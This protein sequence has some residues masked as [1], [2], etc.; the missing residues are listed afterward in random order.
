MI[1]NIFLFQKLALQWKACKL[2]IKYYTEII[3]ALNENS[4]ILSQIY[5]RRGASYERLKV[6]ESADADFLQS[7]KINPDDAYVLNYLAY[8]WLG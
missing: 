3:D 6:Y 4:E 5:Y 7:L 2:A 8:S 1:L